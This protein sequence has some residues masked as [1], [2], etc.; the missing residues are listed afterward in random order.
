MYQNKIKNML[1]VNWIYLIKISL[2][3]LHIGMRI[4]IGTDFAMGHILFV[5]YY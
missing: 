1:K 3:I 5:E 2:I 4:I